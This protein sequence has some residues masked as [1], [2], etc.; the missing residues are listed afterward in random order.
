MSFNAS[1]IHQSIGIIGHFETPITKATEEPK[2]VLTVK[3]EYPIKG[4]SKCI[5]LSTST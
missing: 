2:Q 4:S 1:K 3:A 5:A